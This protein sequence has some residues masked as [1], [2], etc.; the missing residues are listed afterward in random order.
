[1]WPRIAVIVSVFLLVSIG[2]VMVYSASSIE[3]IVAGVDAHADALRQVEFAVVG[4]ILCV[5]I[6]RVFPYHF[7][8]GIPSWLIFA[9]CVVML[10]C[11]AAFG[12]EELGAQRWVSFGGISLQPSEF[13]KIGVLL[14]AVLIVD[15]YMNGEMQQKT[16][17]TLFVGLNLV[18]VLLI[19]KFQSD[20]GTTMICFLGM[21]AVLLLAEVKLR[22][23]GAYVV[24]IGGAAA[25]GLS[26]GYRLDRLLSFLNPEQDVLGTGYQINH[27]L[28]AF[29]QGGLFGSGIGGS[30]E[31]YLYLPEASTDF[32]FSIIGEELGLIGTMLILALFLV[33]LA[34]GLRMA[35]MAPD[36]FGCV[37]CASFTIMIV[38]QAFLNIGCTI[39]M[40]PITGKPLPFISAGGSS[41]IAS[42]IMV[43]FMLAVSYGSDQSPEYE[44]RRESIRALNWDDEYDAGYPRSGG[45]GMGYRVAGRSS[46][47]YPDYGVTARAYSGRGALAYGD[48]N[49]YAGTGR[50][51]G[52]TIRHAQLAG[53]TYRNTRGR[54]R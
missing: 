40:L 2:V 23:I 1:M 19:F 51:R 6:A 27:S 12:T 53:S 29:A 38:F 8:K 24:G 17:L 13:A 42:L 7:W 33:F 32:I 20:M 18:I 26:T 14:V 50:A 15:Q 41:L 9:A 46:R 48:S 44:R 49:R 52:S 35:Q 54:G 16:F 37:L 47:R 31:K 4:L 30:A 34:G 21:L 5:G 22:F 43:G 25:V 36:R 11:T 28:Y 3:N 39:G 45:S 10:V